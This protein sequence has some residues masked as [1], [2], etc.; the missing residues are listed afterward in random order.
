MSNER[1][2]VKSAKSCGTVESVRDLTVTV[3][4]DDNSSVVTT[5]NDLVMAWLAKFTV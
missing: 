5:H 4:L 3:R 2:W 1:V